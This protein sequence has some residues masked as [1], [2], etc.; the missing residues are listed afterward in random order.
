M[1]DIVPLPDDAYV[2]TDDDELDT[3]DAPVAN[4]TGDQTG[5]LG[6]L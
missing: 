4:G 6:A 2:Y 3:R 1:T 5:G